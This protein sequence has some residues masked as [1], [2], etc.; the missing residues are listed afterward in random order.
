MDTFYWI[1]SI[2]NLRKKPSTSELIDWIRALLIGGI[3]PER[4]RAEL[5][6]LGVLIKK[7]EDIDLVKEMQL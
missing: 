6:F 4:I 1:R 5:P 2:R 7:D 3:D